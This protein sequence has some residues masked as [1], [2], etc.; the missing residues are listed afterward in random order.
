M[1]VAA[2]L[3]SRVMDAISRLPGVP[4]HD[5]CDRAAAAVA[6]LHHP[7]VALCSMATIDP[8]GFVTGIELVGVSASVD[9]Q[10]LPQRD[11]QSIITP[12]TGQ[13]LREADL[14]QTCSH[15]KE[16]EWLGWNVGTLS[17]GLWFISTAS[18][19]G[20]MPGRGPSLLSKR[21]DW[22]NPVDVLLA[23]VT[24]DGKPGRMFFVEVASSDPYMRDS[25]REQAVLV[26]TLPML[27]QRAAKAFGPTAGDKHAWLTPREELVM[28]HLVAGMKVPDI[29][30]VLH[31]SIYTV[32]DHVKS[33]HRKL[34]ASN[35]G[36]LVA[37]A[38]G[39][40]GPLDMSVANPSRDE[41]PAS[42]DAQ[43]RV[44]PPKAASKAT[45]KAKQ[46]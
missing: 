23:A 38:L 2:V 22:L 28:W 9:V 3:T 43:T 44:R 36:Q 12:H 19:Q 20:L 32:H 16:N 42:T 24:V 14:R 21:W 45:A 29:A 34:N 39:H 41:D 30:E 35:R 15:F 40:L 25:T 11:E 18:Q 27:A 46:R 37:R 10:F 4:T 31:R 6:R 33:L 1:K 26:A 8:R 17:E 5:W 13:P 7:C